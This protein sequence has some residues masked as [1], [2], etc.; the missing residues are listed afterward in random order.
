M[1][2]ELHIPHYVSSEAADFIK[3][4]INPNPEERMTAAQML[5]H[6][7]MVMHSKPRL[8]ANSNASNASLYLDRQSK[9]WSLQGLQAPY[10]AGSSHL[11]SYVLSNS[12]AEPPAAISTTMHSFTGVTAALLPQNRPASPAAHGEMHDS[13]NSTRRQISSEEV[14]ESWEAQHAAGAGH[15]LSQE[16]FAIR[17]AK[18]LSNIILH[19]LVRKLKKVFR[20]K[21][22]PL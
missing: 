10:L 12:Q 7:W 14:R 11:F 19:T 3:R 16:F 5:A 13:L 1:S 6:P 22:S 20:K 18:S 8:A 9:S 21:K 17:R 2:G 15:P 4:T